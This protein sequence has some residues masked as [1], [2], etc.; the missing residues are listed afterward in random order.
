MSILINQKLIFAI[1]NINENIDMH[2]VDEVKEIINSLLCERAFLWN[3]MFSDETNLEEISSKLNRIVAEPLLSYDIDTFKKLKKEYT[4]MD[5]IINVNVTKINKIKFDKN[6]MI[7][8]VEIEWLM[9]SLNDKYKEKI[10]YKMRLV[11]DEELWK[12]KDYSL[13]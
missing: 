7:V 12:I 9:D 6:E 4:N 13:L 3:E 10:T 8:D 2:N 5:K 1:E 11:R